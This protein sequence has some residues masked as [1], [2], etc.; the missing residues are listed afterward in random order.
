MATLGTMVLYCFDSTQVDYVRARDARTGV[1]RLP[2]I[3][4]PQVGETRAALVVHDYGSNVHDL[5]VFLRS[6]GQ[7]TVQN[8]IAGTAGQQGRYSAVV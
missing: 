3:A 4:D 1:F 7:H 2:G 6:G 5:K 8:V